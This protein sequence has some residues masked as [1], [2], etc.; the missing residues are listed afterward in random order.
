[1][2]NSIFIHIPTKVCNRK[3]MTKYRHRWLLS[4]STTTD[5]QMTCPYCHRSEET[6]DHDQFLTCNES[7]E[8]KEVRIHSFSQLLAQLQTPISLTTFLINGLKLAYQKYHQPTSLPF[9]TQKNIV[10]L[11]NFIRGIIFTDLTKT[12]TT[13]YKSS[14]YSKQQFTGTGWIKPSSNSYL[15]PTSPNGNTGVN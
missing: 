7:E 14:T 13:H 2:G 5:N 10:G 11:D 9:P 15:K 3:T 6:L 1:M 8:R 12:M 4:N